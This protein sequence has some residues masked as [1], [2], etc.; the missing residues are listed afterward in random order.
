MQ[1]GFMSLDSA[2]N[3]SLASQIM[4]SEI[5]RMRLK[6]W[7]V[8]SVYTADATTLDIDPSFASVSSRFALVRRTSTPQT[9][10]RQIDL[11]V[12]WRGADG[13]SNSRTYTTYYGRY[14]LW[15]YYYNS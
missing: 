7:S 3:I 4:Q 1:R 14:G 15:D 11:T 9:D 13:R 12:T 2:R 6:D 8:V 5:E 10:V